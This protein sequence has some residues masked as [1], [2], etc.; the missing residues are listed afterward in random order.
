[1]EEKTPIDRVRES[2]GYSDV[3]TNK[4]G[5]IINTMKIAN[6]LLVIKERSIY[7]MVFADEV[8]P[9]RTNINLPR[10]INKLVINQGT[11]SELV[12][13]TFLMATKI[14][15]PEYLRKGI[16]CDA[17]LNLCIDLLSELSVLNE[18]IIKYFVEEEKVSAEYEQRKNE[19]KGFQI[20]SIT[21]IESR[22]KTIFQKADHIE[23]TLMEIVTHFYPGSGL[24]KQSHFP[25]FREVL[26]NEHGENSGFTEFI[27]STITFMRT[28]RELRNGLDHRLSNYKLSNFELQKSGD[29][30]APT[31][32]LNHKEVKMDRTS[33]GDFLEVTLN[34]LIEITEMTF[35]YL[36]GYAAKETG[37]AYQM[38][39]I[40]EDRRRHEFVRY[41]FWMPIGEEGF[42][43]Q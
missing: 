37:M 2:S 34:N 33:L 4:D 17:I 10:T 19:G 43:C 6:R 22:C 36:A 8:D 26:S 38:K 18:E 23:Q 1:M 15:K 21:N 20:P 3:G 40:P 5:T 25:R 41:S 24:K 42:Y 39:K 12:A 35:V 29:I 11:E 27:G 31:I 7:E 9:D 30:I 28:I 32:E 14:F 13:R 16:D